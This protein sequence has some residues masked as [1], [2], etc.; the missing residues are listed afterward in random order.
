[1]RQFKEG[2]FAFVRASGAEGVFLRRAINDANDMG[3]MRNC[4]FE[5]SAV[6]EGII[7]DFPIP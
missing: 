5:I 7:N 1:M 2:Q 6:G 4:G 3:K